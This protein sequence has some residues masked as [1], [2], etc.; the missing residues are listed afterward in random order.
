MS[1]LADVNV[2]VA[3]AHG[4]HVFHSRVRAW[5]LGLG[6]A[7]RVFTCATTELGLVRAL[8]NLGLVPDVAAALMVLS[9]VKQSGKVPFEF[10]ADDLGAEVMPAYVKT[11]RQTTDGHLL[12]LAAKHGARFATLDAGIPG[13]LLIP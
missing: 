4:G 6:A 5:Y 10:I 2:L 11:A 7:D 8:I 3:L 12:M 13:A 9:S 1:Y